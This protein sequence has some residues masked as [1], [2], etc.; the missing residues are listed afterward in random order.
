MSVMFY[1]ATAMLFFGAFMIRYRIELVLVFPLVALLMAIYFNLAFKHNSAVQNPEKLYRG[2]EIDAVV[3]S[4]CGANGVA[5][6]CAAAL[7]GGYVYAD[8]PGGAADR[9]SE[10]CLVAEAAAVEVH[11]TA[12]QG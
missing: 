8:D 10:T 1:A 9:C 4:D 11:D 6:V 12:R 5:V 3:W 7:A 2:A